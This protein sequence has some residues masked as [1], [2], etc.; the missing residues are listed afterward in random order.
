MPDRSSLPR[1]GPLS[2]LQNLIDIALISR[3]REPGWVGWLSAAVIL[4]AITLFGSL[5]DLRVAP[6]NLAMLYLSG[7]VV[8][9]YRWGL[10]PALVSSLVSAFTFD[11]FLFRRLRVLR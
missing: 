3:S 9:S 2:S 11:F 8:I 5:L 7:V 4:A 6:T 10:G 1:L